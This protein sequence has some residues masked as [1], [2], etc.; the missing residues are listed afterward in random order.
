MAKRK[1]AA[2]KVDWFNM[3]LEMSPNIDVVSKKSQSIT[4]GD[5]IEETII[6]FE[7]ISDKM[8]VPKYKTY[9]LESDSIEDDE[10]FDEDNPWYLDT[11]GEQAV[12]ATKK[13]PKTTPAPAPTPAPAA[14]PA[15][16][17]AP[18]VT[19]ENQEKIKQLEDQ[20]AS[21]NN[22]ITNLDNNFQSGGIT[23]EEYLK[24]KNFLAEKMGALMG[25]VETIK[26]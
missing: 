12:T 23:Q 11:S 18:V 2:I 26:S 16:I 21:I 9:I 25:Q 14:T 3:R 10:P 7:V 20:I 4:G 24:K 15:P 5:D 19:P 1:I 8:D 13:K 22:M 6:K 17:S